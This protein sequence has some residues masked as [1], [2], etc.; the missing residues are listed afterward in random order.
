M[1]APR[2]CNTDADAGGKGFSN[3][4]GGVIIYRV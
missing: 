4:C 1:G 3:I 2:A